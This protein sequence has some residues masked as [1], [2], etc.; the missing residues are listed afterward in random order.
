MQERESART[1][2]SS[3]KVGFNNV[4]GYYFEVR[5]THKD[6]VPEEWVRKQTLVGAE[7]YINNELKEYETRILGAEERI[8]AIETRLFNE[9]VIALAE[10]ILPV[11]LD[12]RL[13]ATLDVLRSFAAVAKSNRYIRP[14]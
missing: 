14:V 2:I 11:Q 9:L 8:L 4:F 13:I 12:A 1:G 6:K 3:L 7:R 10:Y 5:N